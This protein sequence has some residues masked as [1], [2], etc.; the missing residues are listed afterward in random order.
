VGLN[1]RG[2]QTPAVKI[3]LV[4][5]FYQMYGG[6]DAVVENE[7]ATLRAAGH[8]VVVHFVHNDD[9]RSRWDMVVAS[10]ASFFN[11]STRRRLIDIIRRERVDIVHVHNF[12]P[13]LSPSVFSAARKAGVPTVMTL[14]NFRIVCPTGALFLDGAVCERSVGHSVWW[15]VPRRVYRNSVAGTLVLACLIEW[16]KAIGTWRHRV[17]RFIALTDFARDKFI[18]A[19]IPAQLIEVKPNAASA[20][21]E[22]ADVPHARSGA[23]FVGRLSEEKGVRVLLEAWRELEVPL[24]VAGSGPM[25]SWAAEQPAPSAQL[26]GRL[27]RRDVLEEMNRAAFLVIP[28]VCYEM[29]PVALA[30][31]FSCG[32]PVIASKLGGLADLVEE[33][34]TG[35]Q[36][37]AGNPADLARA[38]R[39]AAANP[40]Q[41]LAMGENCH[42]VYREKFTPEANV[43]QLEAIYRATI[44]ARSSGRA[45]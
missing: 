14:H 4:H 31:A 22:A 20:P 15:A 17:D 30:E 2:T 3:L 24:R 12:F 37:A 25:E 26:L 28:S 35:L 18:A 43:A 34:V 36:F 11:Y 1:T 33:G 19:G 10:I 41:M 44:A 7:L 40:D 29:F 32:L 39:W 6:E 16:H 13:R 8:E 27:G 38:V 23:L 42:R 45:S 5:N 9:I 21:E